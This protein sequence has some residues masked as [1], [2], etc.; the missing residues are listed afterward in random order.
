MVFDDARNL[1]RLRLV[2]VERDRLAAGGKKINHIAH[3]H[4]IKV[5]GIF[6]RYF[7][8]LGISQ[9]RDPHL[10]RQSAVIMRPEGMHELIAQ[11]EKLAWKRRVGQMRAIR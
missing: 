11:E 4:G 8:G 1:F 9:I 3:P 7:Y 5:T 6:V 10:R 2:G